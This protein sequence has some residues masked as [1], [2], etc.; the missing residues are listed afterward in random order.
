MKKTMDKLKNKARGNKKIILFLSIIAIIGLISGS[1]FITII[2]KSD[3]SLTKNYIENFIETINNNKLNYFACLKNTLIGNLSFI[4]IIWLL[5][6]S[7]IGLPI[8]IFMYFSKCFILGFSVSSFIL[9]YKSKGTILAL[10]YIFPHHIINLIIYTLLMLYAIKVSIFLF[11]AIVKKKN[12]NFKIIMRVYLKILI[13]TLIGS[14]IT[15]LF[16]CFIT[17]YILNHLIFIIK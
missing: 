7:L 4:F 12:I 2:S 16:E 3:Q 14:I 1:M 15:S 11:N 10:S 6:I 5:G 9:K 8:I 13:I 17:P